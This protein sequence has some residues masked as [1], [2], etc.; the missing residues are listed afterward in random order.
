MNLKIVLDQKKKIKTQLEESH[1]RFQVLL[2]VYSNKSS[3]ALA[4]EKE[5]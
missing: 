2:Q 4:Y 3:M 5:H 1:P